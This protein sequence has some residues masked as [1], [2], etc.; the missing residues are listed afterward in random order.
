M[1]SSFLEI[2][3]SPN[4]E[5]KQKRIYLTLFISKIIS[6]I[7]SAVFFI[8]AFFVSNVYWFPFV[9][10]ACLGVILSVFQSRYYNFYDYSFILGS[11]RTNVVINNKKS[12]PF[13]NFEC[14]NIIKAGNINSDFYVKNVQTRQ[15]KVYK[16]TQNELTEYDTAF[17]VQGIK[18]VRIIVLQFDEKFL[19]KILSS[20]QIHKY[21]KEYLKLI[22]QK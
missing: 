6:I 18:D 22:T 1:S 17:L 21:D 3:I 11:V 15:Y 14:A 16:A 13:A 8:N 4:D 7:L 9:V 20:S 5:R 10:F 12:K 2:S 19:S